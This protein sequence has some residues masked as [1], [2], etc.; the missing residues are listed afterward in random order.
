MQKQ[1]VVSSFV[2]SFASRI[3]KTGLAIGATGDGRNIIKR[4]EAM[5][6]QALAMLIAWCGG[7]Q[8]PQQWGQKGI[9]R[10]TQ[11][12]QWCA[13]PTVEGLDKGLAH[14][15]LMMGI[16]A[17]ATPGKRMTFADIKHASHAGTGGE[18]AKSIAGV[19]RLRGLIALVGQAGASSVASM[20]TRTFGTGGFAAH[21]VTRCDRQTIE[22]RPD[23]R[24]S[25]LVRDVVYALGS[26]SD[27]QAQ[28][29]AKA[30]EAKINSKGD[31]GD[32]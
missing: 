13:S 32:E 10:C 21:L 1:N 23:A 25:Q 29:L 28:A 7:E 22:M 20:T 6:E 26:M 27:G 19:N 15:L 18:H 17:S 3:N 14:S 24:T 31:K 5:P 30:F 2:N 16:A 12:A 11:L 4:L 8:F 9:M